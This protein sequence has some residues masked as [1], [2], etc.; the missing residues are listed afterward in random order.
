MNPKWITQRRAVPLNC[1]AKA[2]FTVSTSGRPLDGRHAMSILDH[3]YLLITESC[4]DRLW[5]P[6]NPAV[7]PYFPIGQAALSL[8]VAEGKLHVT[9]QTLTPNF[10]TFEL[11]IDGAEWKTSS[12]REE[13][14]VHAGV[15]TLAVRTMNAF[16]I[17]GPISV[18][19]PKVD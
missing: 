15:N 6:A 19:E 5:L 7:D 18:A 13:W 12:D 9:V 14:A 4:T 11:R 2:F 17:A 1:P 3:A 16:G 8:A 10:K